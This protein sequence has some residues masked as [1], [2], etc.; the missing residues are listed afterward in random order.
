MTAMK[1]AISLQLIVDAP[2]EQD[3]AQTAACILRDIRVGNSLQLAPEYSIVRVLAV[4]AH[5]YPDVG[6]NPGDGQP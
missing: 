6:R 1:H 5:Q 3:P 4:L 2:V